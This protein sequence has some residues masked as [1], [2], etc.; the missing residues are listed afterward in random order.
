M[1]VLAPPH[2]QPALPVPAQRFNRTGTGSQLLSADLINGRLRSAGRII[3]DS[4]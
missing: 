1:A 3:I 2:G 4:S